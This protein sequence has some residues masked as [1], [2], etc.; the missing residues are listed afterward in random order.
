MRTSVRLYHTDTM[1]M[2][3]EIDDRDTCVF[4]Y[5]FTDC[6]EHS[7]YYYLSRS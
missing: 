5:L 7:L 2:Y 1:Q 3:E 6:I 4:G